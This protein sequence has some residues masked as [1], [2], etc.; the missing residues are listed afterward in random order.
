MSSRTFLIS[1]I[2][3]VVAPG[4]DAIPW[5]ADNPFE[6]IGSSRVDAAMGRTVRL[7]RRSTEVTRIEQGVASA[8]RGARHRRQGAQAHDAEEMGRGL[9]VREPD[10]SQVRVVGDPA[11]TARRGE[12]NQNTFDRSATRRRARRDLDGR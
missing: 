8:P 3:S 12:R 10:Q 5:S 7:R 9:F 4:Q 1:S 6:Q 2:S 11:G